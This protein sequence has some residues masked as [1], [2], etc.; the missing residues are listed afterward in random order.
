M[1]KVVKYWFACHHEFRLRHSKCGGTKHKNTRSGLTTA[2]KS[3]SYLNFVF[4]INCGP[5]QHQAFEDAWKHKL[6]LAEAFLEKLKEKDFPGVQEVA[7]L[8]EQLKDE[9]NTATWDTRALFPHAHKERTVRVSLGH[10]EKTPSPLRREVLPEDIPEPPEVIGPDHPD[11]EYDWDYVASTDPI[12]PVDTDY[13]HPLDEVDPGWMLNHLSPEEFEQCGEGVG[14]DANE[15][16]TAWISSLGEPNI[17]STDWG[18]DTSDWAPE[19]A[20]PSRSNIDPNQALERSTRATPANSQI[21]ICTQDKHLVAESVEM[22]IHEFWSLVNGGIPGKHSSQ[23]VASALDEDVDDAFKG[24]HISNPPNDSEETSQTGLLTPPRTPPRLLTDGS[25]D[26]EFP[27]L[28][29]PNTSASLPSVSADTQSPS[30]ISQSAGTSAP[31][32]TRS[33]YDRWRGHISPTRDVDRL[34]FDRELLFLSRCEIKDVEGPNG[35]F[36]LDPQV[37]RDDSAKNGWWK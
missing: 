13:A 36:M 20:A 10:F 1:C 21:E 37:P 8:V 26:F 16:N 32:L 30:S 22:V 31:N 34:K 27:A 29:P 23:H 9:F 24:L 2:C 4:A 28:S 7:A 11:Y 14:F 35:R 33:F 5:C 12:H 15:A 25:C 3:E 17:G 18:E 19:T 6:R